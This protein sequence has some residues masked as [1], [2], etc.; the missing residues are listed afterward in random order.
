MLAWDVYLNGRLIDTVF[1]NE[2]TY[3]GAIITADEI[4]RSLVEHDDYDPSI[5]VKKG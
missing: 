3:N 2:K 5:V 1:W 4:K